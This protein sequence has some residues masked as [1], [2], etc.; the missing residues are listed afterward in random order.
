[1][2]AEVLQY[3]DEDIRLSNTE[4]DAIYAGILIDTDNFASKTGV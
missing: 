2:I 3:F 4:A 1:M